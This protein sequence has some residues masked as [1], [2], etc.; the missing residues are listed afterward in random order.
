MCIR[1]SIIEPTF[2][3]AESFSDGLAAVYTDDGWGY[4]DRTGRMVIPPRFIQAGPFSE[5]L[6]PV[7][8]GEGCGYIRHAWTPI[9]GEIFSSGPEPSRL[10]SL[11][12]PNFGENFGL[13]F[14]PDKRAK[15]H[16]IFR[17]RPIMRRL[18]RLGVIG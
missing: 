15:T 9:R 11:G 4:I 7:C 12:M 14:L 10:I 18:P 16:W 6:A 5:G 13:K 3:W 17:H 2:S 1:D 8:T